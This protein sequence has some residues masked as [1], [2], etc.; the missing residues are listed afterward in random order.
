MQFGHNT[1]VKVG[2]ALYHVQTE[3][4]GA[5]Q[6]LIET[7]V[8]LDG[9]VVHRQK[10]HY[11]DLLPLDAKKE[12]TLK[13]RVDDQHHR[14]EEELR[15]GALK[16]ASARVKQSV[17]TRPKLK[18]RIQNPTGWLKG[19]RAGLKVR[20]TD[21]MGNAVGKARV[22]ARMEGTVSPVEV[23]ASSDA[24]GL[25]GLEFEIPKFA[26]AGPFLVIEANWGPVLG[27][28]RLQLKA[29]PKVP[30]V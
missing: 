24:D 16:F 15:T 21:E 14:I 7:A 10:H 3:D 6:A 12:T 17:A 25:V 26:V 4:H 13:Q 29:R 22:V 23:R 19:R 28:L 27:R 8:Y 9:R 11:S 30:A 2:D 1:N 5:A 20:I 18:L